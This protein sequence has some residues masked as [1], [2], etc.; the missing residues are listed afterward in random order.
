MPRVA[1]CL[2][3]ALLAGCGEPAPTRPP[4][5]LLLTIDTLRADRLACY[6]GAAEVGTGIC[7]LADEGARFDWAISTAPY[8]A[9][10][11][12]SLLTAR[13]PSYHSVRQSGVSYLRND[14]VTLAEVLKDAGYMTAAFVSNPVL[15]TSRNL[16]QGFDVYDVRMTRTERNRPG[17]AEREAAATTDAALA[18]AQVAAEEPWFLWV[19]FQDPHGPY[20]P[21]DADPARDDPDGQ[22]L[23]ALGQHSGYQGIPAYQVLPGLVT[24]GAYERRYAE[25][26]RYLD[27]HVTR[28]V[29]GLDAL[30]TRPA[31]IVT[32][33]HGESF[34]EDGYWF[35]HGHSV[36]L[37]QIRVPLLWRPVEP[38]EPAV[39][40]EPVS[41]IDVA[42]T[43]LAAA[44]VEPPDDF[45]G[46]PLPLEGLSDRGE[47]ARSAIFSEHSQYK[48]VVSDGV[49][50]ARGRRGSEE[51][52]EDPSR[53][54]LLP[55]RT[56]R[57]DGG[58]GPLPAYDPVGTEGAT[59]H[60]SMLLEFLAATSD[61][62]GP[63]HGE[64][65]QELIERM[66]ALGYVE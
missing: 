19:H 47:L 31:V 37:D 49:Y 40:D 32:S 5:L 7:S 41:L 56:A 23:A 30:G 44:G 34:G 62:A 1:L 50:Y 66:Q 51:W 12:A 39:V 16:G 3:V 17:Y 65:P 43:L 59:R 4:N 54:P 2:A 53:K 58:T 21:P 38:G 64:I 35:A 55:P 13:Y 9:P 45:Q 22:V 6:G 61:E 8:T 28:L 57:L 10:S 29:A 42:P 11:V 36:S 27:P 46:H 14:A 24:A 60:E 20:E 18:W 25:E 48:A 52:A 15:D 26:I 63:E 33:D